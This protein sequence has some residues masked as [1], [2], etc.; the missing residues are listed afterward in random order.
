M[1]RIARI[2]LN[3][4]TGTEI[5]GYLDIRPDIRLIGKY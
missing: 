5:A 4:G 2:R 1:H 3:T